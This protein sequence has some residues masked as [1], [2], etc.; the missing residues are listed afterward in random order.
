MHQRL[1]DIVTLP[2]VA[3]LC[4]LLFVCFLI[5][6]TKFSTPLELDFL[7]GPADS[8][9]YQDALRFQEILERDGVKLNILE[10]QGSVDNV[11]QLLEAEK[12]TAAFVDAVGAIKLEQEAQPQGFSDDP[13]DTDSALDR[14][15]SLG[16]IYLQPM[17]IFRLVDSDVGGVE[18]MD[19]TRLG[20]GPKG[21]TSR[22]L[23]DLFL[24]N[25]V[26]DVQIELVEI[27]GADET[28]EVD[29]A[30]DALR[31]ALVQAVIVVGQPYN[32][33]VDRLLRE[34]GF[35]AAPIRRAEAYSL[36][37]HY[38]VPIRL[39]EGGYDLGDNV[40]RSDVNT[41]AAS[42]E[43]LVTDMFPPPLADLLLQATSE[44]HGEASLF[45][46][47]NAF[48]NP[49][50]VAIRLDPSAARYYEKGPPF[51]R[52]YLPFQLATWIDRFIMV[53]VAF[54]SAAIAAFS[55]L[56][57]LVTIHLDRQLQA[58]YRR[59]EEIEKRLE[60]D[61][62][63]SEMLAELDDIEASTAEIRILLRS[64][65]SSWLEMRQFLHDL[66]ERVAS[67]S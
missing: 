54:G 15:T 4:V 12:P 1:S 22:L 6:L 28:I 32:P 20:V 44:V 36:H 55:I 63:R 42:T 56:P 60:A 26:G 3:A 45:T 25:V 52:K 37:F 34:P 47:R 33:L 31:N 48:P 8:T 66:R 30:I 11:Q 41:L 57:R 61:G 2:R 21:S 51:L 58:A 46:E 9:F 65:I 59:M 62:D 38:L 23:A 49:E 14:V 39:P 40:P 53:V 67:T 18:E 27:G 16:A 64:T 43:L 17:W 19:G 24:R 5:V 13:D 29:E 50:M 35:E 10:T 7:A